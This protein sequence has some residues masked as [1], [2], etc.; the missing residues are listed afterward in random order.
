MHRV[1]FPFF[2]IPAQAGIFFI[3]LQ[4]VEGDPRLRGDDGF[5]RREA[6][7]SKPSLTQAEFLDQR[8]VAFAVTLLEVVKKTAALANHLQQA[9]T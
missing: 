1:G 8:E 6:P 9:T 2:I 5:I 7:N 4:Q 3:S